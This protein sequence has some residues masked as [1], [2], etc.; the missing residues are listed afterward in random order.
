MLYQG[1]HLFIGQLGHFFAL[2]SFIASLVA[3]YSYFRTVRATDV[4]EQQNW[5]KIA[6]ASFIIESIAVVSIFLTLYI[7]I[8][9]HFFEYRYAQSHSK[10][11]LEVKYLLSCFWEGQEGSFMLWNFW[12]CVLG[13]IVIRTAKQWEAPLC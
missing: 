9:N 5:K 2:L 10:R 3:T 7:I 6:R 12:H 1:E 11:S 13:L 8:Y 4:V